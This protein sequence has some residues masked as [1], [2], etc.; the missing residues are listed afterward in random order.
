MR[1]EDG[2]EFGKAAVFLYAYRHSFAQRH[3]DAGTPV[4][5]LKDLMGHR[6]MT[7]TQGYYSITAKRTRAA[8]D[9]LAA[10]QFDRNGNR[11]WR[12]ARA[13]L[14]SEHQRLAV[15]Q[16]AVP[17]GA[18]SEPSNVQAGG[19]ACPFRFRCL[20]CGHFRTDPSYLPELRDYLDTLLRTRERVRSACDLEEWAKTEAM[21]SEAEITRLRQ[22]IR[23]AEADLGQLSDADRHQIAHAVDTVR[24]MRRSV[25]LGM[26]AIGPDATSLPA[27][28]PA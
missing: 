5:V 15:G 9:A 25:H 12:Q 7:T 23:R 10:F 14:D 26:P 4:D 17:F 16:V 27:Q 8:V 28:H 6:S 1:L 21:P 13:L 11:V 20:G 22:L 3:A 24:A 2:R 19:G 18:C